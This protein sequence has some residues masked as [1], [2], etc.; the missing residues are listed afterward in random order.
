MRFRFEKYSSCTKLRATAE[1]VYRISGD[2]AGFSGPGFEG[3]FR[4]HRP[5]G[6]ILT[7]VMHRQHVVMQLPFVVKLRW[8]YAYRGVADCREVRQCVTGGR[9]G[10]CV[11]SHQH[12]CAK[13]FWGGGS[14][15]VY[16]TGIYTS[17]GGFWRLSPPRRA[18]NILRKLAKYMYA[19]QRI[20][21]II[22]SG[23]KRPGKECQWNSGPKC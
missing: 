11:T 23:E 17:T 4:S 13:F 7:Y 14:R 10:L 20:R 6:P 5:M 16:T 15:C 1:F 18:V 8:I 9:S 12:F 2:T 22:L 21:S 3:K 19:M